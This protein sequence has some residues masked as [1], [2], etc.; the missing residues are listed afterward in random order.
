M[1]KE[2]FKRVGK[3]FDGWSLIMFRDGRFSYID[4]KHHVMPY[5]FKRAYDF[6]GGMAVVVMDDNKYTYVT[7]DEKLL[8]QRFTIAFNF[9]GK[10][11]LAYYDQIPVYVLQDGTIFKLNQRLLNLVQK[12]KLFSPER[13]QGRKTE[14]IFDA[15]S[16]AEEGMLAIKMKD[17]SGYTFLNLETDLI[18]PARYA[19]VTDFV[20][21]LATV[22]TFQ[23][24]LIHI[25]KRG[26]TYTQQE[27]DYM[28]EHFSAFMDLECDESEEDA[29]EE[30]GDQN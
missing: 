7:K 8:P 20:D 28:Y 29:D 17:G 27:V 5:R 4:K 9:Y 25:D 14:F 24:N 15:V 26:K 2:Q 1:N 11:G 16:K 19:A 12:T 18:L 30:Y 10:T 22:K 23:G 3:Q 6:H 13:R 21:G